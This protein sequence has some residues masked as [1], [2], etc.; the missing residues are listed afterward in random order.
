MEVMS[1]PSNEPG[2]K[3]DVAIIQREDLLDVLSRIKLVGPLERLNWCWQA[4]PTAMS[5]GGNG[6][7]IW[8]EFDRPDRETGTIGRGTS[9]TE[10]VL[11]GATI[12][13]VV[14]TA[15]VIVELSMRHEAM[16]SFMF[17]GVRIFDP[18][19][20]VDQLKGVEGK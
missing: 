17:D 8:G 7:M 9:R 20:T 3:K 16:E 14:K 11:S 4:V 12:S 2:H 18:H 1:A 13:Y 15:W 5:P 10:L 6:W 19:R